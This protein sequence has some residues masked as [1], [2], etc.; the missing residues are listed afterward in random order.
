[1]NEAPL[2]RRALLGLAAAGTAGLLLPLG[3]RAQAGSSSRSPYGSASATTAAGTTRVYSGQVTLSSLTVAAG[4]TV[5]L[6]PNKSTKLTLR[7]NLVVYGTL[8]AKPANP[9]I[10]HE[11]HFDQVDETKYVGGGMSVLASD[12]GLW[13]MG[14]GRLDLVGTAREGWNRTGTSPTWRTGDEI[15]RAPIEPGVYDFVPHIPGSPVP[16]AS[17]RGVAYPTEVFNL[18]RNVIIRG[19]AADWSPSVGGTNKRAHVFINSTVPQVIRFVEFRHLAPRKPTGNPNKPTEPVLG[20]YALHFHHCYAGSVGTVVEG[21]VGR[22]NGGHVFVPHSSNGITFVDCVSYKSFEDAYWW[23]IREATSDLL[24]D[25]CAAF[26]MR[27]DPDFRGSP[28]GFLMGR[29]TNIKARD[30][31]VVDTKGSKE[32]AGYHWPSQ[33]NNDVDNVWTFT[34]CRAHNNQ[35]DGLRVWQN[36]TN[37]HLIQDFVTFHNRNSGIDHGAYRNNYRYDQIVSFGNATGKQAGPSRRSGDIVSRANSKG[38]QTFTGVSAGNLVIGEHLNLPA[39][40]PVRFIDLKVDTVY[41]V[42]DLAMAA[43]TYQLNCAPGF[44]LDLSDFVVLS[45]HPQ[46]TITVNR[47]NGTSFKV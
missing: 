18:T 3:S 26:T 30:C 27:S 6:D 34:G 4:E 38:N 15:L 7:G 41:V 33:L 45:K 40:A 10:V 5:E 36:D 31:V 24:Y 42:E 11:I 44:D 13:V 14:A 22:E 17:F 47:S 21:C 39:L 46:T 32:A 25:R 19:S 9:S 29:G 2:S 16:A 20:R 35:G 1:M 43:G 37:D 28:S 12:V 8:R 23:D